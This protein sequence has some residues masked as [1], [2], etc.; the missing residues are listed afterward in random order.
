M[1]IEYLLGD[2]AYANKKNLLSECKKI[3]G[4]IMLE[5]KTFLTT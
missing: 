2:S 4:D 5:E 1:F 3:V